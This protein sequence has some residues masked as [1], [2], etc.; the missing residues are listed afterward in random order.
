MQYIC[1]SKNNLELQSNHRANAQN[2]RRYR[3]M[4][5]IFSPMIKHFYFTWR[6]FSIDKESRYTLESRVSSLISDFVNVLQ[7]IFLYNEINHWQSFLF[8]PAL[9]RDSVL[10][11][12]YEYLTCERTSEVKQSILS[13]VNHQLL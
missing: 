11:K 3:S 2:C 1:H 10:S 5:I 12:I 7:E 13:R 9:L 6:T 4:N 8:C